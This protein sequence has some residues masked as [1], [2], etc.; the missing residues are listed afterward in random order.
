MGTCVRAPAIHHTRPCVPPRTDNI[1]HRPAVI[2]RLYNTLG[3]YSYL[4]LGLSAVSEG[5]V[6]EVLRPAVRE[7]AARVSSCLGQAD[8][9]VARGRA[10]RGLR[11]Q[12]RATGAAARTHMV[13]ACD[14][15]EV[16]LL[17]ERAL[18][19]T[20]AIGAEEK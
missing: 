17:A 20:R 5:G 12:R 6:Q 14:E 8:E 7:R 1:P 11:G 13:A 9:Q 2:D 19:P 10:A 15:I 3:E 18:Q 4:Y 16:S